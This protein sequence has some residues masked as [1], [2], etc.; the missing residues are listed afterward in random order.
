MKTIKLTVPMIDFLKGLEDDGGAT[1]KN[2]EMVEYKTGYQVATTGWVRINAENR[3]KII[4]KLDG[5]F[6]VWF[7]G[8]LYYIDRSYRVKTKKRAIAIGKEYNQQSILRW[9][10]KGLVWL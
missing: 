4:N 10:D 3:V 6:G 9:K 2:G 8:G 5:N 7:S 1:F